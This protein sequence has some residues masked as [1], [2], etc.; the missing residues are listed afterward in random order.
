MQLQP[1]IS[2]T[3]ID[4]GQALDPMQ[5]LVETGAVQEELGG[6]AGSVAAVLEVSLERGQQRLTIGG[7]DQCV[8]RCRHHCRRIAIAKEVCN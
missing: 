3:Q 6:G 1:V 5:S 8:D 2:R 7:G 4:S